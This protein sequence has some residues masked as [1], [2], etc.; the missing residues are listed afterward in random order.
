MEKRQQNFSFTYV[1]VILLLDTVY[2]RAAHTI[3][4]LLLN[5]TY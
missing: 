5:V 4:R 3:K 2:V 1:R